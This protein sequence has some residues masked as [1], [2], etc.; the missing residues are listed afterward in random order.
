MERNLKSCE[1]KAINPF[2]LGSL[3]DIPVNIVAAQSEID[4]L[5]TEKASLKSNLNL[6][7]IVGI[8]VIVGVILYYNNQ[9]ITYYE[10]NDNRK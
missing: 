10:N 4:L 9:S 7:I 3:K 6:T 5:R 2:D 8:A 1:M